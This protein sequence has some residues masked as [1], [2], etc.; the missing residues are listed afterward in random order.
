M[1]LLLS[2]LGNW[3]L[4]VHSILPTHL[5]ITGNFVKMDGAKMWSEM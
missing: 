4:S 1:W 2:V 3:F 5:T